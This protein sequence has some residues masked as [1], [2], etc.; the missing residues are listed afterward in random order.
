MTSF[1]LALFLFFPGF[2]AFLSSLGRGAPLQA[3]SSPRNPAERSPQPQPGTARA[4]PAR[5]PQPRACC[6][7]CGLIL[8]PGSPGCLQ[9]PW[10][11]GPWQPP[12][13][14]LLPGPRIPP[15]WGDLSLPAGFFLG[16]TG[17]SWPIACLGGT[18]GEVAKLHVPPLE[19]PRWQYWAAYSHRG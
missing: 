1:L 13:P 3:S 7:Q 19:M 6:H 11:G 18:G 5:G 17:I 15:V 10:P 4:Q 16:E 12:G 8:Q 14:M 2:L 9:P